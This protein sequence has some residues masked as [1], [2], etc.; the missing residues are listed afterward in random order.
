MTE[1][2]ATDA[3]SESR[4]D[5]AMRERI[6]AARGAVEDGVDEAYVYLKQQW[7]ERPLAVAG[8]ALGAGVLLGLLLSGRR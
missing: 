4:A 1:T 3:A 2:K 6:E 8:V 5:A 7:R